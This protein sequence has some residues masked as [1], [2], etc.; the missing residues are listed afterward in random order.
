VTAITLAGADVNGQHRAGSARCC[1]HQH[2]AVCACH[3]DQER[4]HNL[5]TIPAS[6]AAGTFFVFDGA[7]FPSSL[8]VSPNASGT[9]AI[10]VLWDPQ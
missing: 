8:V 3:R 2:R 5:F 9:G 10:S 6:A 7:T 4:R 1:L